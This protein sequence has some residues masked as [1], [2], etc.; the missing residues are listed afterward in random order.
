MA[1]NTRCKAIENRVWLRASR[2]EQERMLDIGEREGEVA[3]EVRKENPDNYQAGQVPGVGKD[4]IY[5]V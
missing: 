1:R 4:G 2:Q 3:E 5:L